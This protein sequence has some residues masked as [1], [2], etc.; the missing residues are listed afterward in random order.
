MRFFNGGCASGSE[1]TGSKTMGDPLEAMNAFS[2]SYASLFYKKGKIKTAIYKYTR[3]GMIG[4]YCRDEVLDST[5]RW[6]RGQTRLGVTC[7]RQRGS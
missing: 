1:L 5:Y 7:H 4:L 2:K 6:R 3:K